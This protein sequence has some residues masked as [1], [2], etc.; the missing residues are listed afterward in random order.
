MSEITLL[1]SEEIEKI[2]PLLNTDKYNGRLENA[3]DYVFNY[4]KENHNKT[5][6]ARL[7]A[8]AGDDK[9]L[10]HDGLL[11]TT[12]DVNEDGQVCIKYI[13]IKKVT[14]ASTNNNVKSIEYLIPI[15][16]IPNLCIRPIMTNVSSNPL[17]K[18]E[19][20]KDRLIVYGEYPQGEKI[21][22]IENKDS[23]VETGKRYTIGNKSYPEYYDLD[24]QKIIKIV[25]ETDKKKS[26]F[27]KLKKEK[28]KY[29]KIEKIYWYY[30]SEL[31]IA[32]PLDHLF[33][34]I[35]FTD[36]NQY[37]GNFENTNMKRFLDEFSKEILPL[38]YYLLEKMSDTHQVFANTE[39]DKKIKDICTDLIEKG[40]FNK[41]DLATTHQLIYD[42]MDIY[43]NLSE[44]DYKKIVSIMMRI[45]S[46]LMRDPS[47]ET[48]EKPLE[49]VKKELAE[50]YEKKEKEQL[51]N[52]I[53]NYLSDSSI[54]EI[55]EYIYKRKPN[56]TDKQLKEVL[57]S[58]SNQI[59]INDDSVKKY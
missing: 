44:S 41:I 52:E 38:E 56:Y 25:P 6:F 42:V 45:N 58:V 2:I 20:I 17:I 57:S 59:S 4:R 26:I 48:K 11:S 7:C 35:E 29:I 54:D 30:F 40:F 47:K 19:D 31:D 34:G 16:N 28:A 12:R 13:D 55:I 18:K 53:T 14:I 43:P 9:S 46:S 22:Y 27:D 8:Q 39:E 33:S 10:E 50:D 36:N 49:E 32:I 21:N 51:V 3:R 5:T 23:L 1:S 24:G 37:T 15:K